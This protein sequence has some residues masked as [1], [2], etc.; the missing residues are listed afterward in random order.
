MTDFRKLAGKDINE[1]IPYKPGKPVKELERELG[2]SEAIKLA[3]NENSLGVPELAKK[4]V[5]EHLDEMNFYPYGDAFYLR[6]KLSS[7]LEVNPDRLLFGTGSNEIIELLIRT[8]A[9]KGD[10][11]LS[12]FPSFS[13][14]GIIAKAAGIECKWIKVKDDFYVDFDKI[15]ENMDEKVRIVF[16]ANPNNPT[17]TYISAEQLEDF[18]EFVNENTIVVLDEAYVEYVDAHDFP[19]TFRLINKYKNLISM[20]TFS[21]AYGLA[22]FR[23][24]Y[25]IGDKEAIDMLNRVRQPFNVNMAGQI[26]AEAAL[27]D[28]DFLRKSIKNNREGKKYLYTEF[29]KLGLKYVETQANFILVNVGDGEKIFNKLLREG[30]IVRFLGEAL[31]EYIRVTI[32][33]PEQNKIFIDKLNKV[34]GGTQ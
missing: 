31:K 18:M 19:N 9:K 6:R 12:Y 10:S 16:L 20:R 14:Y 17:G 5:I 27:D 7:L 24:G 3:S 1:L 22:G 34:L 2:I 11:I 4:A 23:V 15:K 30:V 21:K 8:F 33:T 25:A 13:V 29:K 26:A 32:G 28:K